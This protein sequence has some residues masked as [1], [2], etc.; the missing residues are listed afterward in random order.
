MKQFSCGDVVP[1]CTTTFQ[2]S[3]AEVLAGIAKHA[4]EDH[5]ITDIPSALFEKIQANIREVSS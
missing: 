4:R 1:G 3:L 2:G 5:G